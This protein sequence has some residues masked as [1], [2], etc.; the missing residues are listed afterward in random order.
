M[1]NKF[2]TKVTPFD[3][4]YFSKAVQR[5]LSKV[6]IATLVNASK[7]QMKKIPFGPADV[8][9]SFSSLVARNLIKYRNNHL[10][11]G[12]NSTWFVTDEAI[13]ILHNMG[14]NIE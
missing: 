2:P 7:K 4:G 10:I 1:K 9:G 13:A 11:N 8:D 6:M 12:A 3:G 5:P 14:I